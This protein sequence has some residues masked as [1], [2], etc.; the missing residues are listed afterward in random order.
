MR[1]HPDVTLLSSSDFWTKITG[2]TD[3]RARLVRTTAVLAWL[4]KRRSEDETARIKN[5]AVE[6]FGD[7]EGR[8]DLEALAHAPQTARE[9]EHFLL[10][11]KTLDAAQS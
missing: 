10:R 6:L 9:E 11:R 2:I 1:A 8:L 5:E 7:S 3:F 4:V